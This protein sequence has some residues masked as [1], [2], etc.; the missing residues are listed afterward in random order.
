MNAQIT[1]CRAALPRVAHL[2]K[3]RLA[4]GTQG[5]ATP[6]VISQPSARHGQDSSVLSR[7][8]AERPIAND[9]DHHHHPETI[10]RSNSKESPEFT[11]EIAKVPLNE[12]DQRVPLNESDHRVTSIEILGE[13][14]ALE[15][16]D[17]EALG[18]SIPS[19]KLFRSGRFKPKNISI[20]RALNSLH[21]HNTRSVDNS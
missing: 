20:T 19:P 7:S 6:T 9:K 2:L 14:V 1:R 21:H 8:G 4:L 13:H 17:P 16:V 18:L 10:G 5:A 3:L 12:S 15:T 11:S